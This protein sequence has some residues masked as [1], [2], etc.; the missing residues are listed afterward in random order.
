[1]RCG[2]RVAL[3]ALTAAATAPGLWT[4]PA[5]VLEHG[6]AG[7]GPL[8]ALSLPRLEHTCTSCFPACVGD[9]CLV[10]VEVTYPK[11]GLAL[12]L[13]PPFPLILWSGGFTVDAAAYASTA[14]RLAS[15]GYTVMRY[16]TREALTELLD[17]VTHVQLIRELIDWSG[18]HP[19]VRQLADTRQGVMLAGHSR[20][21]KLSALA[22]AAD[23]RVAGLALIDPVDVTQYAPESPRY[24]SAASALAGLPPSRFLPLAV[25]GGSLGGA[26]APLESN[27]D[28]F[29]DSVPPGAPAWLVEVRGAG[30]FAVLDDATVLQRIVCARSE[31]PVRDGAV[32][33]LSVGVALALAEAVMRPGGADVLSV[34]R[35]RCG[36]DGGG[37]GGGGG[38]AEGGPALPPMW[39]A[40]G[41]LVAAAAA[42]QQRPPPAQQP[43]QQQLPPTWATERRPPPAYLPPGPLPPPTLARADAALRARLE[44]SLNQLRY[45]CSVQQGSLL[46]LT[47]RYKGFGGGGGEGGAS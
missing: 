9:K 30:H 41:G 18:A 3:G 25:V 22:A 42:A 24:P 1:M 37:G 23:S 2:R 19:L 38:A 6:Y 5:A 33:V 14:S 21:A 10:S 32:R 17:D 31:A 12:G 44:R 15:W 11:G 47:V 8:T 40:A 20:G 16:N 34:L 29:F 36:G 26:C 4:P 28:R 46:E 35:R 13:G 27:Y 7:P 39:A 43:P 45:Q